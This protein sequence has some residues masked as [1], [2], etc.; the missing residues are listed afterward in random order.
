MLDKD[1]QKSLLD[2]AAEVNQAILDATAGHLV[3]FNEGMKKAVKADKN[4]G[5]NF[6][7]KLFEKANES[8]LIQT[9]KFIDMYGVPDTGSTPDA[10]KYVV[11]EEIQNSIRGIQDLM[12]QREKTDEA[13]KEKFNIAKETSTVSSTSRSSQTLKDLIGGDYIKD[14]EPTIRINSDKKI[15]SFSLKVKSKIDGKPE[16]FICYLYSIADQK[17]GQYS[18]TNEDQYTFVIDLNPPTPEQKKDKDYISTVEEMKKNIYFI[19]WDAAVE[20]TAPAPPSG[21]PATTYTFVNKG[22][23]P[24]ESTKISTKTPARILDLDSGTTV[25]LPFLKNDK[26]HYFFVKTGKFDVEE[27]TAKTLS[28]I[29]DVTLN[30]EDIQDANELFYNWWLGESWVTNS[31]PSPKPA[32][33]KKDRGTENIVDVW[34]ENNN[35][36][37][38][39]QPPVG[40]LIQKAS[41]TN[42]DDLIDPYKYGFSLPVGASWTRILEFGK[43]NSG[44][45]PTTRSLQAEFHV[46]DYMVFR[47]FLLKENNL[48][49]FNS[50]ITNNI[51][52]ATRFKE[53]EPDD[54]V[55][56][57]E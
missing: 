57:S 20:Q 3:E 10:P 14:G 32:P 22:S 23:E 44:Q 37:F 56:I 15:I 16:M 39:S 5:D 42:S 51:E 13:I 7:V 9:V 19:A 43:P 21:N 17:M 53:I 46:I 45:S 26:L 38:S 18:F 11:K 24:Y 35:G 54:L 48:A 1:A 49:Y 47:E 6:H 52:L 41:T 34:I 40:A 31:K 27:I 30:E 4:T 12:Q 29:G 36:L 28:T 55:D 2:N 50:I 8:Q 33:R 25:Y